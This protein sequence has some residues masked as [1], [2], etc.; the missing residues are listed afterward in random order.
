M[1]LNF[2]L[3][4]NCMKQRRKKVGGSGKSCKRRCSKSCQGL[5]LHISW[6]I[7]FNPQH[8]PQV[9]M[10]L[11]LFSRWENWSSWE[12]KETCPTAQSQE[13][14]KSGFESRFLTIQPMLFPLYYGISWSFFS[15]SCPSTAHT[16]NETRK[17]NDMKTRACFKNKHIRNLVDVKKS[18]QSFGEGKRGFHHSRRKSY[19]YSTGH[20][21]EM[22]LTEC[23]VE[24][25]MSITKMIM[26]LLQ[27]LYWSNCICS[28]YCS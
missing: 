2:L 1:R 23:N 20:M 14:R 26:K 18:I 6:A 9:R 21:I 5:Y 8:E 13:N 11:H 28:V 17:R 3:F 27:I 25:V 12:T 22:L 24:G 19:L 16:K 4:S 7:S 10:S 15:T